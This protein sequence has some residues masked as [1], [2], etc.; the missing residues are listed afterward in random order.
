MNHIPDDTQ[1]SK[2]DYKRILA[3]HG[4]YLIPSEI[5][6][7]VQ[8]QER[9]RERHSVMMQ[10]LYLYGVGGDIFQQDRFAQ[11]LERMVD[12]I[13]QKNHPTLS[14][15]LYHPPDLEVSFPSDESLPE[16]C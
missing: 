1:L 7:L 11:T 2:K 12:R 13:Y 5:D 4:L 9:P 8:K 14:R 6:A 10:I 16:A 3:G 15:L